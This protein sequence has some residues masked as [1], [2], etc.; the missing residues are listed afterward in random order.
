MK[1][2]FR[3]LIWIWYEPVHNRKLVGI[4]VLEIFIRLISE[5]NSVDA[6]AININYRVED[7]ESHIKVINLRYKII[8]LW[9][10]PS[11][12]QV[13]KNQQGIEGNQ[14]LGNH[15]NYMLNSPWY[16]IVHYIKLLDNISISNLDSAR[17]THHSQA[18]KLIA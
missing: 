3:A 13:D 8:L 9:K 5:G 1:Q 15:N 14:P 6:K 11:G 17:P 18:D 12:L 4:V 7:I 10:I 2:V 16:S